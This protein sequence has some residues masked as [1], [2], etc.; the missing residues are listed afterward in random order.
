MGERA[1]ILDRALR[2]FIAKGWQIDDRIEYRAVISKE[3]GP[4]YGLMMVAR[5]GAL[6]GGLPSRGEDRFKRRHI[7]VDRFGEIT[8]DKAPSRGEQVSRYTH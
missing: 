3:W 7:T 8:V 2:P 6:A 4:A 1:E 5:I